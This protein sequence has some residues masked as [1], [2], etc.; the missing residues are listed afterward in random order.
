MKKLYLLRHGQTQFNA[1]KRL[2]GHCNSALT[3]K[4]QQQAT[5]VGCSLAK[6]IEDTSGWVIYSSPLG[7]AMETATIVAKQL[8]MDPNDIHQ[9]ARLMEYNLGDW[10][11]QEIPQLV[12]QNPTL[13]D[14]PDWYLTA[15]NAETFDQVC[16]R[17]A[18]FLD[19]SSVPDSIIVVS[20]GL[21]GATLRG[22]YSQMS[23]PQVW[24]QD[25]PQDAYF[26]LSHQQITRIQA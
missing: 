21:T 19:D 18:A 15:P 12:Q 7:R 3:E 8:G 23:Y 13:L 1:E 26:L 14:K 17:L 25:L 4:G 22:L 10:E 11:Q 5:A 20:H 9:D 6:E 2:Q 16:T 24:Q